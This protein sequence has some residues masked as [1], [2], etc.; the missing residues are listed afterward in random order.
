MTAGREVVEDYT[1][2]GLT[3]RDHPMSFLRADLRRRRIV[4]CAEAG[5]LPDG[6]WTFAAGLV[7]VRQRPGSAKGVMFATLEDESGVINIVVWPSL[8]EKQRG[9]VLGAGLLAVNGKIQRE[10]DVVHLVAQRLF[11]LTSDLSSL[12]DRDGETFALPHGRGDELRHGPP[13]PDSRSPKEPPMQ[14]RN[15]YVPDLHIDT[16]KIKSRNFH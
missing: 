3:L 12:S 11:D 14:V 15:I 16:L 6:R 8:F 5:A 1:R 10:G 2:I 7:L 9:V 4:T 13:G